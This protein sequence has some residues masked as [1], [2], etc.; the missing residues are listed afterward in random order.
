MGTNRFVSR[1]KKQNL[2][3]QI[4]DGWSAIWKLATAGKIAD[5]CWEIP[6]VQEPVVGQKGC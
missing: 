5:S 2:P 6:F 3:L 4:V 1:A